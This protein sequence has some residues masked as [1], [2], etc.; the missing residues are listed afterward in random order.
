MGSLLTINEWRTPVSVIPEQ[1][2]GSFHIKKK[3]TKVGLTLSVNA[4]GIDDVL[5]S[6]PVTLTILREGIK[7]AN[8]T[9]SVWMSDTPMEYYMAWELVARA[10]GSRI[11]V[12]G[13]GLGLLVHLLA[14]R[15]DIEH[16]TVVEQSSEIIALVAS[17]LPSNVTIIQGDFLQVIQDLSSKDEQFDT[18]IVD[19]WKSCDDKDKELFEDCKM[20]LEDNYPDSLHLF[21]AF[22]EE[23]DN[24]NSQYAVYYLRHKGILD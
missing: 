3:Q 11:L 20:M 1:T 10:K 21:W 19:I 14:L 8:D 12:G 6:T 24:E 15:K 9:E 23:V 2:I 22:Q 7:E 16:M 18:I 13:L 4:C 5:F 17:Y